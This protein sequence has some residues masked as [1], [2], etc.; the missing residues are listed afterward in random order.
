MTPLQTLIANRLAELDLTYRA[1]SAKSGGQISA[2]HLNNIV[3]GYHLGELG[4]A[5]VLGIAA[6]IDVRL[7]EVQAA[8]DASKEPVVEFRLPKKANKLSPKQ[9]KAVMAMVN[10]LLEE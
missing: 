1:A 3:A 9:R 4:D 2:S 7:S 10:A 5:T 6:A 8:A